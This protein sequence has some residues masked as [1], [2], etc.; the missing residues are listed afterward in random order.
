M[1]ASDGQIWNQC[2]LKKK[3]MDGTL[4]LPDEVPL[5]EDIETS[6]YFFVG[7]DAFALRSFPS[8]TVPQTSWSSTKGIQLPNI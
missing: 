1:D 3:A 4:G 5:P 7:D 6:P 8:E 2:S